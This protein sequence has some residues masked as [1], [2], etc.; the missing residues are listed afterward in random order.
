MGHKRI[1]ES[2]YFVK[3]HLVDV[4]NTLRLQSNIFVLNKVSLIH[5]H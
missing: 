2:I 4:Y 3:K 1:N 5:E